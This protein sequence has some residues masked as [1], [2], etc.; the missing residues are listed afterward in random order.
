VSVRIGLGLS[1]LP[2]SSARSLWRWVDLCEARAVD[3]LWQTERLVGSVPYLEPIAFL[4][5]LAGATDRLKFGMS[6]SVVTHRDP[7]ILAKE[8]ATIDYLSGGRLLPAFGV[9]NERAPEWRALGQDPAER[10][11]RADEILEIMTRLWTEQRVDFEG[12]FYHYTGAC[13]A[14]KPV[15]KPL[16]L[17]IGGSSPAAIRR[18]ARLGTGW[19]A[20]IQSPAQ[21]APVALAIA[22]RAVEVGR[23]IDADHYGAGFSFRFGSWDEPLV[24]GLAKAFARFPGVSDP[25]A[26]LAVGGA[27]AIVRRVDE[28]RAAGISKFVLRPIAAGD[29]DL[30]DQTRRLIE[31]VVPR[32]HD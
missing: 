23:P 1:N 10:G 21:V 3:S 28:Y 25:R 22:K 27:D 24:D 16:P 26:V 6:V 11:A 12:R 4:G 15:Q 29:D 31:E 14:P 2:F 20:G 18:T 9:G 19:I 5:A 13:I 32:V 8:C 7:L 17:W 30:M